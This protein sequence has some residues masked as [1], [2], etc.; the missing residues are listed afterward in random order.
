MTFADALKIK[1]GSADGTLSK[2]D[3]LTQMYTLSAVYAEAAE[4][5]R[6]AQSQGFVD[7]KGGVK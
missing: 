4:R 5:R 3:L 2:S 7:T 1:I 6:V